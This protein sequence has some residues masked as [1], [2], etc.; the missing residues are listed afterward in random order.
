M[1]SPNLQ[2][3][4]EHLNDVSDENDLTEIAIKRF[5]SHPS[6]VNINKNISKTT[7]F[8]FDETETDSIKKMIDNLDSRNTGTFG[9]IPADCLKVFQ[10]SLLSFYILFGMMKY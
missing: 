5:K 10:I 6:I 4:P 8:S 3:G 9:R 7:T 1:K 2:C